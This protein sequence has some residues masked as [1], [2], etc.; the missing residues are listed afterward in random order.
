[1]VSLLDFKQLEAFAAV[2][3][4]MS[5]SEA[6]KSLFLTQPTVSAHIKELES[7][8]GKHLFER[9]TKRITLTADGEKLYGYTT[10]MLNLRKKA[11]SDLSGQK[12][13]IIHIGSSTLPVSYFLP[14]ALARFREHHP[15]ISF[16]ICK[17]DSIGVIEKML[18]GT[19]DVGLTGTKTFEKQCIF[20]PFY[21]DELVIATPVSEHFMKLKADGAASEVLFR[22][23]LIMRENGSGTRRE[24]ERML[25]FLGIPLESLRIAVCMNDPEAIPNSIIAG[26]GI[27]IISRKVVEDMEK[28]GKLLIFPLMNP[29]AH[30]AL[31]IVWRKD[32]FL[33]K[34]TK[35][36]I[37]M[38]KE[39]FYETPTASNI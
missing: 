36:F 8:L 10:R 38:F 14:K 33:N 29:S 21:E 35:D 37:R 22:E 27:S 7:E 13:E 25:T 19:L 23:P 2:V 18:D 6:A 1:M 16:D 4:H 3:E 30:R 24:T 9:T 20:E 34:H 12:K 28:D 11:L 32:R 5:F 39:M 26:V 15:E 31:Y 17:S